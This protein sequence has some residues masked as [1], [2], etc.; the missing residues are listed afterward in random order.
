MARPHRAMTQKQAASRNRRSCQFFGFS[1]D[2]SP[3]FRYHKST[4]TAHGHPKFGWRKGTFY[5]DLENSRLDRRR[6]RIHLDLL[7][8]RGRPLLGSD[9]HRDRRALRR[10][11]LHA[12]IHC[13]SA[14]RQKIMTPVLP[15][16]SKGSPYA[17]EPSFVGYWS[18]SIFLYLKNKTRVR[19]PGKMN[20]PLFTPLVWAM[21]EISPI[22][23]ITEEIMSNIRIFRFIIAA[24]PFILEGN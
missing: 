1:V 6:R 17:G 10:N 3:G 5:D 23:V 11:F 13:R 22:S 4:R 21:N 8:L 20:A 18:A 12:G 15:P 7:L 24:S 16:Y 19:M 9:P 14:V 2:F